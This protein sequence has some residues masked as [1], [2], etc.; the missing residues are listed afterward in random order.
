LRA[1]TAARR[2]DGGFTLLELMVSLTVLAVGIGAVVHVF[3]SAFT[4]TNAGTNRTRAVALASREIEAMRAVPYARLGFSADQPGY[5]PT[6][7]SKPTVFV[8]T[9]LVQPTGPDAVSGGMT[10]TIHRAVTWADAASATTQFPL[11]YKRVAVLVGWTDSGGPHEV[12]QDAYVYPG[13][14]G[15]YAGPGGGATTTTTTPT[16]AS[17]PPPLTLA[18]VTPD[19]ATVNLAWTPSLATVPAVATWTVEYSTDGFLTSHLLTDTQPATATTYTA[20]GLSPST[21]YSFRVSGETAAGTPSTWSPVASATTP[22]ATVA[23]CQLGTDTITPAAIR[24]ANNGGLALAGNAVVSVNV[25]GPCT[26]LHLTFA[27]TSSTTTTVWLVQGS[28]GMWTG[29][30]V[31]VGT[32]WDTGVHPIAVVDGAGTTLGTLALTVCT[33]NARACP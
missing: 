21:T 11:A 5:Q 16:G 31:G 25:S 32:A 23:Q 27:P 26:G 33:S 13:G 29:T 17:P 10:F 20:T 24:R 15:P 4:V 12:R 22:A 18:A 9:P 1:R 7:E 30:V 14:L 6:W 2:D 19:P 8:A 28:G 3:A